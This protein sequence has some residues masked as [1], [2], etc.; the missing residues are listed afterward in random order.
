MTSIGKKSNTLGMSQYMIQWRLGWHARQLKKSYNLL[1]HKKE[2]WKN[3]EYKYLMKNGMQ[4]LN[5]QQMDQKWLKSNLQDQIKMQ[6]LINKMNATDEQKL[7]IM[8]QKRREQ[9]KRKQK[10]EQKKQLWKQKMQNWLTHNRIQQWTPLYME[11]MCR[12]YYNLSPLELFKQ[13]VFDKKKQLEL[14]LKL[15][16]KERLEEKLQW[17]YD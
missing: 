16:Q 4:Q 5:E 2:L 7:E 17:L 1:Q 15:K 8:Y 12:K 6:T 3:S 13:H 11:Q 9:Q 10:R 14:E